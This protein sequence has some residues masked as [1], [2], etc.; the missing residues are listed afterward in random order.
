MKRVDLKKAKG[1]EPVTIVLAI[2]DVLHEA[3]K[4]ESGEVTFTFKHDLKGWRSG[5][6]NSV[7][8]EFGT[9]RTFVEA[10]AGGYPDDEFS[11]ASVLRSITKGLEQRTED[12]KNEARDAQQ[13]E[14]DAFMERVRAVPEYIAEQVE[15]R[16]RLRLLTAQGFVDDAGEE[17]NKEQNSEEAAISAGVNTAAS[18][19]PPQTY[20]PNEEK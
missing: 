15:P 17:E 7:R 18:T 3:A 14:T 9:V 19:E 12:R 20:V 11:L 1:A 13:R 10:L 2:L 8:I 5:T 6:G 4:S 16:P